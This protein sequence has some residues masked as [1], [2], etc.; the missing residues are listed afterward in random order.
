MS[1][2]CCCCLF[3]V[4]CESARSWLAVVLLETLYNSRPIVTLGRAVRYRV[5]SHCWIGRSIGR[6]NLNDEVTLAG[7]ELVRV[8][9]EAAAVSQEAAWYGEGESWTPCCRHCAVWRPAFRTG[10]TGIVISEGR[11]KQGKRTMTTTHRNRPHFFFFFYSLS[12]PWIP[13]CWSRAWLAGLSGSSDWLSF[14]TMYMTAFDPPVTQCRGS[15]QR[16]LWMQTVS[17]LQ[18]MDGVGAMSTTDVEST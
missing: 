1:S 7:Q 4:A 17:G 12:S 14:P 9:Q 18:H 5:F 13:T 15:Y 3:S 10:D 8:T 6:E 16:T 11:A 2:F